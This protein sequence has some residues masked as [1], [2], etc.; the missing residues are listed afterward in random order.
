MENLR[1]AMKKVLKTERYEHTLAVAY[2]AACLAA[3]YGV[4]VQK[5][6]R[7]GLLHDCAKCISSEETLMLCE[8]YH[9]A[10][11]DLERRNPF[12][13]HAKLGAAL[14][15]DI[16]GECDADILNAVMNHTTGR[17][18]M[19]TLEKIIFVADYI[20]PGRNKAPNLLSIRKMAFADID[21]AVIK[22]LQDTLVY[23]EKSGGE[24]DPGTKETLDFYLQKQ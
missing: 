17:T 11:S 9:L 16:Y 8:K 12:L 7:A 24:I 18:N 4:D 21:A 22:I 10:T 19:S 20:E 1:N 3:I 2:T 6:L 23:L 5:A 14:A 15:A 13:L